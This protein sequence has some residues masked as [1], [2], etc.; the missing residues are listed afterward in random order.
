MAAKLED[1][2]RVAT[3]GTDR[4]SI[5]T[6]SRRVQGY[7]YNLMSDQTVH[8]AVTWNPVH[9]RKDLIAAVSVTSVCRCDPGQV[10]RLGSLLRT[11]KVG[12]KRHKLALNFPVNIFQT[13]S[14]G[15]AGLFLSDL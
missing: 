7:N 13:S 1:Y 11:R 4:V 3:H 15:I 2:V 8:G 12:C 9:R 5:L 14:I 10:L 6:A